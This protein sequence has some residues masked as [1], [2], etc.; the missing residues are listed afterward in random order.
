MTAVFKTKHAIGITSARGAEVLIHIGLDTVRLDGRH[1]EMHVKEGDAVAPGDLLITFDI[2]EIKAAGFDVITPVIITNTDQYSFT[3]VKKRNG[4]TERSASGVILKK[5]W[6]KHEEISGRF[7]G[8]AQRLPIRLKELIKK[9]QR[10][11]YGGCL[12]GRHY[13]SVS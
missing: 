13:V 4:Q 7:Y 10:T 5:R 2:D 9:G 1:F 12:P 8:A 3:D 6:R 11:F